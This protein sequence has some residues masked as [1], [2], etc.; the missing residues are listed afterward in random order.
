MKNKIL[1]ERLTYDDVLVVQ[2][3]YEVLPNSVNNKT[4]F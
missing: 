2:A 4:Y 3:Y 1:K